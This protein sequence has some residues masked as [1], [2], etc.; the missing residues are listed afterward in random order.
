M[1]LQVIGKAVTCFRVVDTIA[2]VIGGL[3]KVG[4]IEENDGNT[5]F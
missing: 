2:A 4:K 1:H 5:L 3:G